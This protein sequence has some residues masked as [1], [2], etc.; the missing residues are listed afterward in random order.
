MAGSVDFL[1]GPMEIDMDMKTTESFD[2]ETS[3]RPSGTAV[4]AMLT[5]KHAV[6]LDCKV[7]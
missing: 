3:E 1:T 4:D 6:M 7:T 5:Y 2:Y